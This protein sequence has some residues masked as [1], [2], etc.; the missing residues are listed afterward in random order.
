MNPVFKSPEHHRLMHLF[1]VIDPFEKE[2]A[3]GIR[4]IGETP[5]GVSPL[6]PSPKVKGMFRFLQ[7][8]QKDKNRS[9]SQKKGSHK[10]RRKKFSQDT[11]DERIG[12]RRQKQNNPCG[13][14]EDLEEEKENKIDSKPGK[15]DEKDGKG[16]GIEGE[17]KYF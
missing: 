16:E 6:K 17:R 14:A 5:P 10:K 12:R 8:L 2:M 13:S 11:K 1:A 15:E 7:H 4:N 9:I 3:K